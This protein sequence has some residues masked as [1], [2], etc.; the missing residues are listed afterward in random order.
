MVTI[1]RS[2]SLHSAAAA[3]SALFELP[4]R[5]ADALRGWEERRRMRVQLLEMDERTLRDVGITRSEA[6]RE[7]AKP[8]WR[9]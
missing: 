8:V 6:L 4:S 9:R 3:A 5:A 1:F 2:R 7:A